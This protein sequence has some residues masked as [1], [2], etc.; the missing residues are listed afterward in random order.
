[1]ALHLFE[2]SF[3]FFGRPNNSNFR[4]NNDVAKPSAHHMLNLL[5]FNIKH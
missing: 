2:T 4:I 3:F 1:M 5:I